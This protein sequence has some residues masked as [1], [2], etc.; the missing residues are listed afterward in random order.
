MSSVPE[1]V[2]YPMASGV[3]AFSTTRIGGV[4]TGNYASFNINPYCGDSA[5]A[6]AINRTALCALL[7]VDG[8]RLLLPHQTHGVE[9]RQIAD[10]FFALPPAVQAMLLDGVDALM[11]NVPKVC[12][13]V[14]TADCIPLLLLDTEHKAC[15]AIH[16]GWRGTV[17]RIAQK[18]LAT[19][20]AAYGTKSDS[21]LAVI[22]PGISAQHFEVGDEVYEQFASA[23]FNM[24]AISHRED[25]WHI[26]LMEC[27]RQQLVE[28]GVK[29]EAIQATGECTYA[30]ADKYF[31]ARRMGAESGR[32]YTGIMLEG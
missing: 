3:T 27:C 6:V 30:N 24:P 25:K 4:G 11:T 22:G 19:M 10:D 26:D 14:S 13:G 12:I 23:G 17:V 2:R 18:T 21:L 16:S 20:R 9:V 29:P 5:D 28:A 15:C 8:D 31:S 7:G 32:I 1:I